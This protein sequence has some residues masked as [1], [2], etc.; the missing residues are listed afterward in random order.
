[1]SIW[2]LQSNVCP[3]SDSKGKIWRLKSEVCSKAKSKVWSPKSQVRNPKSYVNLGS[4][5]EKQKS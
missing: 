5:Y 2:S 4:L 1:M 3:K